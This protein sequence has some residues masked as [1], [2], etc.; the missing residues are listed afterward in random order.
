MLGTAQDYWRTN[1]I[2]KARNG[3]LMCS[4]FSILRLQMNANAARGH[5]ASAKLVRLHPMIF[6]S[7]DLIVMVAALGSTDPWG[8][9]FLRFTLL[10]YGTACSSCSP[11][12]YL[13]VNSIFVV[14]VLIQQKCLL[15]YQ[16]IVFSNL[17]RKLTKSG[18][19]RMTWEQ[20]GQ[21]PI[22]GWTLWLED[23]EKQEKWRCAHIDI[24]YEHTSLVKVVKAHGHY[25]LP[26]K[27]TWHAG[28]VLKVLW[29][30]TIRLLPSHRWASRQRLDHLS[31]SHSPLTQ[32]C[33]ILECL[34]WVPVKGA[35]SAQSTVGAQASRQ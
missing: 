7:L 1:S 19:S 24:I 35:E 5:H 30:E 8:Y 10:T 3:M 4:G 11:A 9:S 29:C 15:F 14:E 23:L 17:E 22:E 27:G 25:S 13:Q 18:R 12:S 32:V 28:R 20:V 6:W 16:L 26:P 33:T 21:Q 2:D 34:L 31:N